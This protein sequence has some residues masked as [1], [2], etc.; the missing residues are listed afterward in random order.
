MKTSNFV[1]S[2]KK[3]VIDDGGKEYKNILDNTPIKNITDNYWKKVITLYN[4][5][6][7]SDREIILQIITQIQIDTLSTILGIFDGT[8]TLENQDEDFIVSLSESKKVL[9]PE[10]QELFL[11][12]IEEEQKR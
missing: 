7:S 5:L 10:M 9:E 11:S 4:S 3:G 8:I 1:L 12:I 6:N 2:L